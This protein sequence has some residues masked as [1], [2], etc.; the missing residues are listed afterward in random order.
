MYYLKL[1][2]F[3][4]DIIILRKRWTTQLFAEFIR[5]GADIGRFGEI[6]YH[7]ELAFLHAGKKIR[8]AD[9]VAD[10]LRDMRSGAGDGLV[11]IGAADGF[12][13]IYHETD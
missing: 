5:L 12:K 6:H 2:N 10:E 4:N 13:I 3:V 8:I 7:R 9:I 11:A 1:N